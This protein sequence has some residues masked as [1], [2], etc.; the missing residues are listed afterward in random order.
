MFFYPNPAF[1]NR[2]YYPMMQT[3]YPPIHWIDVEFPGS[4]QTYVEHSPLSNPF[5][6]VYGQH[7]TGGFVPSRW[8]NLRFRRES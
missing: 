2:P 4:F 6:T 7:T 1:Y 8:P 3:Y 5:T